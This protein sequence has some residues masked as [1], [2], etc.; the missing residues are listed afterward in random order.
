MSTAESQGTGSATPAERTW[1]AQCHHAT[2]GPY[3]SAIL[4]RSRDRQ[5]FLVPD[6]Q[7]F[8]PVTVFGYPIAEPTKRED[9]EETLNRLGLSYLAE[10][11]TLHRESQTPIQVEIVEASPQ[12]VV[13]RHVDFSSGLEYGTRFT[14][15]AP[16]DGRLTMR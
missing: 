8:T 11:W 5:T 7:H 12:R 15:T 16:I 9:A 14:L 10:R 3:R 2:R 4:E 6:A 1:T 13:L